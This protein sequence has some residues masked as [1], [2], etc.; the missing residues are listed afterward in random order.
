MFVFV[1]NN[2]QAEWTIHGH[3][4]K[5]DNQTGVWL[6]VNVRTNTRIKC[7]KWF[8][9]LVQNTLTTGSSKDNTIGG[10]LYKHSKSL[11]IFTLTMNVILKWVIITMRHKA[12]NM[13]RNQQSSR[14]YCVFCIL[15]EVGIVIL[16]VHLRHAYLRLYNSHCL[17]ERQGSLNSFK[18]LG[19]IIIIKIVLHEDVYTM[20]CMSHL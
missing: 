13:I 2:G 10:F 8:G 20:A 14:T 6:D 9:L 15:Q 19:L 12:T 5:R 18:S 17:G 7:L 3:F 4:F 16:S 11:R 1:L